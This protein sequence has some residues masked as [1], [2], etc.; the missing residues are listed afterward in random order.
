MGCVPAFMIAPSDFFTSAERSGLLPELA[1]WAIPHAIAG[2][3]Q[4]RADRP[5]AF[6]LAINLRGLEV[7]PRELLATL[8]SALAAGRFP[9]DSLSVEIPEAMLC[10]AS[11]RSERLLTAL[12]EAGVQLTID[13]FGDALASLN[14]LRR[15]PVSELKIE[16]HLVAGCLHSDSVARAVAAIRRSRRSMSRCLPATAS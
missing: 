3:A 14:H 9:P 11:D 4:L 16:R 8:E 5:R 15:F 6:G 10:A 2:A 7:E 1:M 12:H 13:D